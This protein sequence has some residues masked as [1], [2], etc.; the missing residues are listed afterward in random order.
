MVVGTC[1]GDLLPQ[2]P[3]L[4]L[5]ILT[6]CEA[7]MAKKSVEVGLALVLRQIETAGRWCQGLFSAYIA[8]IPKAEGDSTPLGQRP[9]CVLP[10]VYRLWAFICLAHLKDWFLCVGP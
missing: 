2:E 8:M 6:G 9:L 3:F 7:A 5:P 1:G 10:V 4:D